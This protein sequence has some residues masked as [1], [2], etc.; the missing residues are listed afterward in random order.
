VACE[1]LWLDWEGGALV[2]TL[3]RTLCATSAQ[4]R[5]HRIEPAGL[6]SPLV[7][8][9]VRPQAALSQALPPLLRHVE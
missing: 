3:N 8:A 5:A 6:R 2:V 9:R 1:P 7:G 4:V